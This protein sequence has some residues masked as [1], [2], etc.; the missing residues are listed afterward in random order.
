MVDSSC[1]LFAAVDLSAEV[2]R[3][4]NAILSDLKRSVASGVTWVRPEHIH[5]TVKFYGAVPVEDVDRLKTALDRAAQNVAPPLLT[6]SGAGTFPP[7]GA[8]RVVWLGLGDEGG[9]LAALRDAVE[10]GSEGVGFARESRAFRPHLTLGRVRPSPSWSGQKARAAD[11]I[12]DAIAPFEGREFGAC[13]VD[14]LVLYRSE[15]SREGPRYTALARFPLGP[16]AA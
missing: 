11:A 10:L 5:V 1:R 3:T 7:R 12:R 15:L 6:V 14:E 13:V 2:A 8:P 16:V 9:R 4:A